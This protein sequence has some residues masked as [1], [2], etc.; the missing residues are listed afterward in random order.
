MVAEDLHDVL[1]QLFDA[2]GRD[3]AA[4]DLPWTPQAAPA[5]LRGLSM[6][7]ISRRDAVDGPHFSLTAAGYRAIGE[8]PPRPASIVG[9]IRL[10]FRP[11]RSDR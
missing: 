2:G 4:K 6:L 8:P 11:R 9:L 5:I 10:M 1:K 7:Y 3:V